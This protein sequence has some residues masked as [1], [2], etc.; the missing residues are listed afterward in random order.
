MLGQNCGDV[1][2]D[3]IFEC[4][5]VLRDIHLGAVDKEV[6]VHEVV[7]AASAQADKRLEVGQACFTS[8]VGDGRSTELD[9]PP[10]GLHK[11]LVDLDAIRR[12]EVGF[13]RV[14]GFV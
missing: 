11:G 6:D 2:V 3:V 10:V 14:I 13:R 8:T 4:L 9:G 5:Q 1:D 12:C 7:C